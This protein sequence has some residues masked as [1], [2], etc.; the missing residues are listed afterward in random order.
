[1]A[2]QQIYQLSART[3][4]LTDVIPTQDAAGAAAAGKNTIQDIADLALITAKVDVSSAEIL[5]LFT[6]PKQLVAA[7]GSGKMILPIS[8]MY[9]V[10]AGGIAYATN[11]DL[12]ISLSGTISTTVDAPLSSASNKIEVVAPVFTNNNATAINAAL[13]VRA[14]GGNPTAGNGTLTVYVTYK[15]ITI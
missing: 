8:A 12:S 14:S 10:H 9:Y 2:N 5:A 13:F 3:L 4:G 15:I 1:M 11:T 7:P 6:T